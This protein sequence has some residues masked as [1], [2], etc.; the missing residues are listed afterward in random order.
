MALA[1]VAG[2]VGITPVADAASGPCGTTTVAHTSYRHVLWIFMENHSYGDVIG[3][4]SAPYTNK[5]A[6][7]CGLATNYHNITH[8][9]LP[10]YIAAT[11]GLPLSGVQK[12]TSDCSPSASCSTTSSSIFSQTSSWR[13]YEDSMPTACDKTNSGEYA[14]RHNPPVYYTTL[15][16]CAKRDLPYTQLKSDLANNQL[17]AF[18]FVTPN[19]IHDTHD[20][21]VAQGDT[22]LSQNMP[23]ILSSTAYRSGSLIVFLTY[24]EGENGSTNDCATNTTDVGCHVVTIVMSKSTPKG[25]RSHRL[26]NHYSLLRTTEEILKLPLLRQAKTANTMKAAFAL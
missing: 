9:S 6:G 4:S 22:W 10:N 24:D 13:A 21:T 3:S 20:G 19:L 11:S 17:P 15:R 8:P 25:T 26:F 16:G 5:L 18:G 2:L 12:F 14:A 23:R 7:E 1:A